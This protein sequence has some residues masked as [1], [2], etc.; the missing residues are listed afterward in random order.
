M[1]AHF[2]ELV[3]FI[4]DL[5]DNMEDSLDSLSRLIEKLNLNPSM[6]KSAIKKAIR[7]S[8]EKVTFKC[9]S[10][11]HEF[12]KMG[13]LVRHLRKKGHWK[14]VEALKEEWEEF[15]QRMGDRMDDREKWTKAEGNTYLNICLRFAHLIKLK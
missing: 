5:V 10:C 8:E 14:S 9:Q 7:K 11:P 6:S 12:D 1:F 2:R 3:R 13:E 4:L 15:E